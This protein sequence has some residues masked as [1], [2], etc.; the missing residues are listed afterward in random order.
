MDDD[1]GRRLD[2]EIGSILTSGETILAIATQNPINSPINRDSAVVTSRRFIIYRPRLLGR[3]DLE[4]V[5]WQDVTDVRL[6]SKMLGAI[7]E[8]TARK[9]LPSGAVEA[10]EHRIEGLD[11]AAARK[12]Y[13]VAQ[14]MEE[15][16]REKNRVRQ[17]EEERARSG[18]VYLGG[19]HAQTAPAASVEDRLRKLK[20]LHEQGLITDAEYESR[21]SQIISEL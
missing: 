2:E 17:M 13:A 5:L 1:Y 9:R 14:E 6:S 15:Q 4:D 3:M 11:R 19:A 20:S 21:K 8:V 12:V 16:W 7:L 10:A 18:G